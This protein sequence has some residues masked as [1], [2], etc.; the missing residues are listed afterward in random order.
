M[1]PHKERHERKK[2]LFDVKC[3]IMCHQFHLFTSQPGPAKG[4]LQDADAT[5]MKYINLN[6]NC[7]VP[8]R[9]VGMPN[10]SEFRAK[11]KIKGLPSHLMGNL[12]F[13]GK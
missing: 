5:M 4:T 7:S 3:I 2:V 1:D 8:R 6:K 12:G 11:R 13:L 9:I 10:I